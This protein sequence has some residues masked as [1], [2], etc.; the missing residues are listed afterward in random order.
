[1]LALSESSADRFPAPNANGAAAFVSVAA[2]VAFAA[3]VAA[4]ADDAGFEAPNEKPAPVLA[5][6][7]AS[8]G[9]SVAAAAGFEA[10]KENTAPVAGLASDAALAALGAPKEN[11]GA[12]A[13]DA[14][15]VRRSRMYGVDGIENSQLGNLLE[16]GVHIPLMMASVEYL[17][18]QALS[19]ENTLSHGD[20]AGLKVCDFLK[21]CLLHHLVEGRWE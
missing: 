16:A 15:A 3:V 21:R 1:M 12:A 8:A 6:D 9:F 7:P 13:V 11:A 5:A 20:A 19:N 2:G 4:A 14:D 17:S 10:P 18:H